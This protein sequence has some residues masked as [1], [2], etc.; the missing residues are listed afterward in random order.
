MKVVP[1]QKKSNDNS[2]VPIYDKLL[3]ISTSPTKFMNLT[4]GP[5]PPNLAVLGSEDTRVR[6]FHDQHEE[7]YNMG[8]PV[9]NSSIRLAHVIHGMPT[10]DTTQ[11]DVRF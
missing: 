10:D 8:K 4:S 6:R 11:C 9:D 5:H 2:H 1:E 7:G 3:L